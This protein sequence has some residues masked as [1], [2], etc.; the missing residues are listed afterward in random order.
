MGVE[1][2]PPPPPPLPKMPPSLSYAHI[3]TLCMLGGVPS[4]N[5]LHDCLR[6]HPTGRQPSDSPCPKRLSNRNDS[7]LSLSSLQ[8][9]QV[10]ADVDL[11]FRTNNVSLL[12]GNNPAVGPV[13]GT[14]EATQT[15]KS[16]SEA[17]TRHTTEPRPRKKDKNV[18]NIDMSVSIDIYGVLNQL[19]IQLNGAI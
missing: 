14:V 15:Q 19:H 5:P 10:D 17:Q 13:S 2:T 7:A 11:L 12:R 8:S 1:S 3:L 6:P 18:K 9:Q 16:C 4:S